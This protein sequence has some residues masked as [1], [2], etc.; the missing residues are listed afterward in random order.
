M[1]ARAKALGKR[2]RVRNVTWKRGE[3]EALPI[4]P[5]SVDVALLSQALHHAERPAAALAEAFRIL[6]PGGR[7][8]LLDLREHHETW[9]PQKLGDR[10]LGFSDERLRSLLEDA[11]FSKVDIRI[12]ARKSGDPFTVLIASGTRAARMDRPAAKLGRTKS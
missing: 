5:A 11:G 10:W 7:V 6:R 4:A 12:G 1:L 9:V 3:L 8:L 2:R